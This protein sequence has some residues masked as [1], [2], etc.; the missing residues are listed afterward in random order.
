MEARTRKKKEIKRRIREKAKEII[1]RA[2]EEKIIK[3]A[4]VII[5]KKASSIKKIKIT[6]IEGGLYQ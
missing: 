5:K 6:K 2:R 4:A 1:W 3:K